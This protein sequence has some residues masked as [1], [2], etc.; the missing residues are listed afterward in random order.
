MW[1]RYS[2][3]T[4]VLAWLI[5][6]LHIFQSTDLNFRVFGFNFSVFLMLPGLLAILF[7]MSSL[8]DS[9]FSYLKNFG[10]IR[11]WL[12]SFLFPVIASSSVIGLGY[13]FGKIK[14][15]NP[16]NVETLILSTIF[17]YP[18]LL[19]W[20]VPS[21]L[22]AEIGWRG[23]LFKQ[24]NQ[25]SSVLKAAIFSSTV[26]TLSY[27]IIVFGQTG[28]ISLWLVIPYLLSIFTTGII[29][30]WVFTRTKSIWTITFLHFNMNLWNVFLFGIRAEFS[31]IIF[32]DTG[33][34]IY[35]IK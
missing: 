33:I 28:I 17:D 31:S 19:S 24:I 26:W 11:Y 29:T 32:Q 3:V 14:Y 16:E 4:L 22:L 1:V 8:K 9:L 15:S 30:C 7:V 25:K 2:I 12:F 34:F 5:S 13:L 18:L 10:K 27:L 21:L 35:L 6:Y 23:F 20:S